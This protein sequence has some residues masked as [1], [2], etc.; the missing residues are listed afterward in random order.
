MGLVCRRHQDLG[1]LRAR[2]QLLEFLVLA[3]LGVDLGDTLEG[4]TC[5]LDATPL[6][7]RGFL[8]TAKLLGGGTRSL[9]AGAILL[10]RLK[11][12]AP[13]PSIDH[14]NMVRRVEQ[15]LMFMLAA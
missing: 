1:V 7:T 14:G 3:W 10:E 13:S 6:R 12:R 9:K 15:A 5:F 8:H 4:K 2:Q 11:R